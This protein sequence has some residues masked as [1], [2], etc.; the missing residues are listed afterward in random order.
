VKKLYVIFVDVI[1]VVDVFSCSMDLSY[2]Y[3]SM[4]FVWHVNL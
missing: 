2:L 4:S 1:E 3:F